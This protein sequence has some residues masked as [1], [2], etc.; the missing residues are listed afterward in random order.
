MRSNI[1]FIVVLSAFFLSGCIEKA[2]EDTPQ[3]RKVLATEMAQLALGGGSFDALRA[4]AIDGGMRVFAPKM[5][6]EIGREL[7]QSEYEKCHRAFEKA[8]DEVL[9]NSVWVSPMADLYAKHFDS[10]EL[11][12][13]LKFYRTQI[14]IKTLR[15]MG[16]LATE[17]AQMGVK[18]VE[19]KEEEFGKVFER[20]LGKALGG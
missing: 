10:N 5:Q 19:S 8:F 12:E 2:V 20:E 17:G 6:I 11:F 16:T 18:L 13:V 9:P 14:G 4:Q 15:T 1:Y 7:T 3:Q